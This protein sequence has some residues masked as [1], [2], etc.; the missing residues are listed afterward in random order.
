MGE[1]SKGQRPGPMNRMIPQTTASSQIQTSLKN[2]NY[3]TNPFQI[4][5]FIL[6]INSLHRFTAIR[7]RKTNPFCARSSI[8]RL[9]PF[10][11]IPTLAGGIPGSKTRNL[12]LKTQ[13]LQTIWRSDPEQLSSVHGD[14]APRGSPQLFTIIMDSLVSVGCQQTLA[15]SRP[16]NK[17]L[18]QQI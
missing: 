13:N 4:S 7:N 15:S 8:S 6:G 18:Q 16:Q 14:F 17:C 12:K 10:Q 1:T 11:P 5:G 2:K 9:P 3:Q